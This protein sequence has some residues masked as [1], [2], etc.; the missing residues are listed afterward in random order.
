MV[1]I[2]DVDETADLDGNAV[3]EA[4]VTLVLSDNGRTN[5]PRY[6]TYRWDRYLPLVRLHF[7]YVATDATVVEVTNAADNTAS[8][9]I[10]IIANDEY[11]YAPRRFFF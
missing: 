4:S 9:C 5:A 1:S 3:F 7:H 10:R 8:A 11:V 6:K 2:D